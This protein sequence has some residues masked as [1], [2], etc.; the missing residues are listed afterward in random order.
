MKELFQ[1]EKEILMHNLADKKEDGITNETIEEV[2]Q[3]AL[4]T[5]NS[6]EN[7]VAAIKW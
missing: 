2:N 1:R 3:C 4:P 6:T 5:E 7:Q